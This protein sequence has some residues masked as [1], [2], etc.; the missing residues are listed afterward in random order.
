ME[1]VADGQ[2]LT[3][4]ADAS[5]LAEAKHLF[6]HFE[7][8]IR[9]IPKTCHSKD[10]PNALKIENEAALRATIAAIASSST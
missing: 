1:T 3:V 5:V 2:E 8:A 9:P 4:W 7:A 10:V 6:S